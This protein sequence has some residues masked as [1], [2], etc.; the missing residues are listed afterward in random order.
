MQL[1]YL[2][3]LLA[4]LIAMNWRFVGFDRLFR[5]R[6]R[7]VDAAPCVWR[8]DPTRSGKARQIWVCARCDAEAETTTR[9]RPTVCR[10]PADLRVD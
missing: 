8:M 1:L 4:A 7:A 10:A 9:R 6:D 2:V 3:L 5:S